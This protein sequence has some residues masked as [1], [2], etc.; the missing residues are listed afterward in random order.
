MYV[1][2]LHSFVL[3]PIRESDMLENEHSSAI[4]LLA[5]LLASVGIAVVL[6]TPWVRR[7]FRPIVE[8]KARWLFASRG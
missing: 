4:W 8:P 5:M 3:Y 7:I 6:A 2:L 1:Y